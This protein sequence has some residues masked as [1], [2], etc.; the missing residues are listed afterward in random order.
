M[1]PRSV[2]EPQDAGARKAPHGA[3]P[4]LV[5]I[6]AMKCGTSSM[7]NYLSAHP[8]ITM[9]R[10]KEINFFGREDRWQLGPA[11][12]A[13]HFSPMARIRGESCPDY[14]KFPR[15][16]QVAGRM[17]ELIPDVMLIYLVRDPIDRIVSHYMHACET[18]RESRPID[19]ALAE[20]KNNKYIEPSCYF[21]QLERYLRYFPESQMHVVCTEEMK[22]DRKGVL[23]DVFRFLRIDDSFHSP[24]QDASYHVSGKRGPVRRALEGNRLAPRVRPYVPASVVHWLAASGKGRRPVERPTVGDPLR[25]ALRRYLQADIDRLRTCL[26]RDFASW[27]V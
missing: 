12:Y 16:P 25:H 22:Q 23:R 8:E 4:N 27:S 1:N 2:A 5:V 19:E 20:L 24:R 9:S 21:T 3:L 6:G 14:S 18:G 26:G 7:H 13:T 11:W 10:Q 17:K 15:F